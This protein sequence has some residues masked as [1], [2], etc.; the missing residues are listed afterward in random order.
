MKKRIIRWMVL[1]AAV[2][3]LGWAL[4]GCGDSGGN[5]KNGGT[6]GNGAATGGNGAA[7]GGTGG[8]TNTNGNT[9]AG[10]GLPDLGQ[11]GGDTTGTGGTD[12]T[13][14]VPTGGDD[15]FAAMQQFCQGNIDPS[16]P[17]AQCTLEACGDK[18]TQCFGADW[19]SGNLA[20]SCGGFIGCLCQ[21]DSFND[22]ACV[23][24]CAAQLSPDCQ[25]CM[26]ALNTCVENSGCSTN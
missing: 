24:G 26:D 12:G 21:C 5:D 16:A 20:G 9:G 4:A 23:Q 6:G 11:G 14:T 17:G 1:P 18:Y 10:G 3:M 22:A 2:L 8:G 7:T 19:A 25:P 13:G 15:S